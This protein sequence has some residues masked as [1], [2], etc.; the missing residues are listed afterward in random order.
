MF[1]NKQ[2]KAMILP[3]LA[4]Q[5]LLMLVGL[6]DTVIVSYA[7]EAAVSGVSLVNSFNT[8]FLN[9]FMALSAGGAV[10][11]S[12]YIGREE[13][14][15]T[16][17]AVSQLLMISIV[18]SVAVSVPILLWN[19]PLLSLMFG[20]VDTDVMESCVVYLQI[21]VYSYP[22]LAVYNTGSALY[23]SIGRTK[24][25]MNISVIANAMN[26][27]GNV[28]GVFYFHAGAAGVAWPSLISRTFSALVITVL[29]FREHEGIRYYGS[30]IFR[31]SRELLSR[32]LRIAVPNG[33]ESGLF[34]FVKVALSSVTALFGT[35]QI[36]ANGIAQSIW[37]VAALVSSAMG[38]VF[39]TVV[40]QCMG[41]GDREQAR[42]YF[43]KLM[44]ITLALSVFW[45]G[46]IAAAMPL[47]VRGFEVAEETSQ[48]VIWLVLIHNIGN[49]LLFPFADALGKGL[50]AAG[51]VVFTTVVSLFTTI[52]LRLVF[53]VLFAV[54]WNMGVIGIVLAMCLDWLVRGGLFWLRFAGGRWERF[55]VI[56]ETKDK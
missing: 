3:L 12:Q 41:A 55:Q 2:L 7:G 14:G 53:S 48:L 26:V 5:F 51:D 22:A 6:S 37:S 42:Y 17:R 56:G 32:M 27:I 45:N 4:E 24:T 50:R 43:K 18:F 49:A 31:W 34:Q 28:I 33:V 1:D 10:V 47:M 54:V 19:R 46:L 15:T 39:I 21:S 25:I 44:K 13:R 29:C 30:W 36:A 16:S 11:V 23:R 38:S 35:Y 52:G 20:K 40:G 9:L 8:I